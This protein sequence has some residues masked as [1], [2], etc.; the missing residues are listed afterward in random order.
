MLHMRSTRCPN[1]ILEL[2]IPVGS[3]HGK[4]GKAGQPGILTPGRGPGRSGARGGALISCA[5]AGRGVLPQRPCQ[6]WPARS[7]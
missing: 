5:G 7:R 4:K 1:A 6:P 3:G 2:A